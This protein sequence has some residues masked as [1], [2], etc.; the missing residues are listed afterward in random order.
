MEISQHENSYVIGTDV[1]LTCFSN[2]TVM[3]IEWID[4]AGL[5]RFETQ[6]TRQQ[7]LELSVYNLVQRDDNRRFT[8]RG[9]IVLPNGNAE[10]IN[11][12]FTIYINESG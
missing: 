12:S 3:S 1:T 8:C 2:F 9:T 7:E 10:T 4:E 6:R 5:S 11:K